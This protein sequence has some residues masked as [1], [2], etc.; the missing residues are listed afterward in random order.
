[1]TTRT[2]LQGELGLRP[3]ELT[4][5]DV[6]E[7][8]DDGAPTR[9]VLDWNAQV[10]AQKPTVPTA[11]FLAATANSS[12]CLACLG[13]RGRLRNVGGF[14]FGR[15]RS[16]WSGSPHTPTGDQ[17]CDT[18]PHL[19]HQHIKPLR[20]SQISSSRQALSPGR[21]FCVLIALRCIRS[22]CQP[23]RRSSVEPLGQM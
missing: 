22:S 6:E 23:C 7:A 17:Q 8:C 18:S 20:E 10:Q 16:L 13:A 14:L 21:A 12:G 4:R 3:R 5:G 2:P 19:R 9:T 15:T 11:T 1:M